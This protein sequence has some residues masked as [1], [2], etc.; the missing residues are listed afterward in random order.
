MER[1]YHGFLEEKAFLLENGLQETGYTDNWDSTN[2]KGLPM[3][4]KVNN[5]FC[6]E[7]GSLFN[8]IKA[9][10]HGNFIVVLK[11]DNSYIEFFFDEK[12][13]REIQENMLAEENYQEFFEKLKSFSD[14]QNAR[15]YAKSLTKYWKTLNPYVTVNPKISSNGSI[16]LQCTINKSNLHR[17]FFS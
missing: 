6:L 8:F 10:N 9:L 5:D 3:Q 7:L 17:L 2:Y 4:F 16:R 14:V 11:H 13:R 1:Q 12:I 15:D